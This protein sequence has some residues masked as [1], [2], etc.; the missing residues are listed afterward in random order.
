MRPA[1]TASA[2]AWRIE[3]GSAATRPVS[4]T[5]QKSRSSAAGSR[6]RSDCAPEPQRSDGLLRGTTA[7]GRSADRRRR[8]RS[9]APPREHG[10]WNRSPGWWSADEDAVSGRWHRRANTGCGTG[11]RGGGRR[12]ED[13]VSGRWHHRANTGCGTGRRG[14]GR[15]IEDAVSDRWHR[16]ANTGC[17]TGRRGGGRRIEDAVSD[18]WHRRAGTLAGEVLGQLDVRPARAGERIAA[19]QRPGYENQRSN[20]RKRRRRP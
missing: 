16:R 3:S 11:R 2:S 14:G 18:R 7:W 8:F 13:A 1:N 17:G 10:V 5:I 4:A 9:M 6:L 20:K 12:I 15:R 19:D